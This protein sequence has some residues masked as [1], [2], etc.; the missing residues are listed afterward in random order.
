[1]TGYTYIK[2]VYKDVPFKYVLRKKGYYNKEGIV[3]S[4][5]GVIIPSGFSSYSG[6]TLSS[7]QIGSSPMTIKIDSGELPVRYSYCSDTLGCLKAAGQS[8]SV[9]QYAYNNFTVVGTPSVNTD[10]GEV[11]GFSSSDY[12]MLPTAFSPSSNTWECILKIKTGSSVSSE[13][14]FFHSCKGTGNSG[15]YGVAVCISSSKFG[16]FVSS[17]GSS[18]VFDLTGTYTVLA[19]TTYWVKFGWDGTTYYLE[20]S[21]DGENYTRDIS[22]TSSSS[23]YSS[24]VYTYFGVYSTSSMQNSFGGQIDLSGSSIKVNN[25]SWW[26]PL[27]TTS[28]SAIGLLPSGVTDDGTAKT[29]NL[30]Y[31]DG[32]FLMST[33]SQMSGYSWCGSIAVP[34]H[35]I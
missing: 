22:Y 28:V 8:Y 26:N 18:W 9:T 17:N 35:S 31:N 12:L 7:E 23:V 5:S 16:Y 10:T 34:A 32:V 14:E 3:V 15:R 24:L 33:A 2:K 27:G 21:T 29:W 13:Q 20:Y 30:F 6:L 25:S 4:Q 1:M 11:S 19:D